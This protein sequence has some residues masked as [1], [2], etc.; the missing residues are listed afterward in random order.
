M[1][2]QQR[3]VTGVVCLLTA[4]VFTILL[5]ARRYST[6][7][8]EVAAGDTAARSSS[9]RQ[10]AI[11]QFRLSHHTQPQAVNSESAADEPSAMNG[12]VTS[13]EIDAEHAAVFD[14]FKRWTE[15]YI[16][17]K[18]QLG[19][20]SLVRTGESLA[21]KRRTVLA[22]LIQSDP[23]HALQM[24]VPYASRRELPSAIARH[25]EERVG[26]K[27]KLEVIASVAAPG[28]QPPRS[29][30]DRVVTLRDRTFKA[31]VYGRRANQSSIGNISLHGIAV[32]DVMAV[33]ES[34]VRLV[35]PLELADMPAPANAGHCP[36]SSDPGSSGVAVQAADEVFYLC[37]AGHIVP[38]A[39]AYI[40]AE[41]AGDRTRMASMTA[42]ATAEL[43]LFTQGEKSILFMRV[44][45][46]DDLE[47]PISEIQAKDMMDEVNSFYVANSYGTLSLNTVISP[48]L[49]LPK[50]KSWYTSNDELTVT[51]PT[52]LADAREAA[53]AAGL[54]QTDL[55]VVYVKRGILSNSRA[56]VGS[57]GA[58]L[59]TV[60][61]Y[62]AAHEIGHNLGLW[63]ANA[64]KTTDGTSTGPGS[65]IEYANSFDTMG[66]G[67]GH[68]NA[69]HKNRLNWLP[70]SAVQTITTS[71]VYRIYPADL[72][73]LKEDAVHALKIRK[74]NQREYWIEA[75]QSFG[76]SLFVNWSANP[77][78]L[79]G[80]QLLDMT[81]E[82]PSFNDAMLAPGN[83]FYDSTLGLKI[84]PLHPKAVNQETIEVLVKLVHYVPVE[85]ETAAIGQP[86]QPDPSASQG[87]YIVVPDR[88]HGGVQFSVSIPES[89]EYTVWTRVRGSS[90]ATIWVGVD[91]EAETQLVLSPAPSVEWQWSRLSTGSFPGKKVLT[92]S[93]GLH[94]LHFA[95]HEGGLMIDCLLIGSDDPTD[96]IPPAISPISNQV[97]VAGEPIHIPFSV[98]QPGTSAADWRITAQSLDQRLIRDIGIVIS[99]DG[100]NRTLEITPNA[101]QFGTAGI[102][103]NLVDS[104]G[105]AI[106]KSF[107][108]SLMGP[109]QAVVE[110]SVPGDTI[111][112]PEGTYVEQLVINKDL[113]L[114]GTGVGQTVIEGNKILVPLT[115]TSNAT[116][117]VRNLTFRKGKTAIRN[118]G[119]LT[120]VESSI[121]E[122]LSAYG[123]GIWNGKNATLL[124]ESSTISGNRVSEQGGGIYNMGELTVLNST[125]SGNRST[126]RKDGNGGGGIYNRGVLSLQNCTITA[127]QGWIGGGVMNV[128]FAQARSTILAV[129]TA[130]AGV[131]ADFEG[132]LVSQ[133]HNL[134]Q[135]IDGCRMTGD[136]TRNIIGQ[137]PRLGALGDNGG[138]TFTH[139]LLPE[140]PAINGGSANGLV[141][142][143]R[144]FPRHPKSGELADG[145]DGS[146]IG[147]FEYGADLPSQGAQL[148]VHIEPNGG[149]S[150][151]VMGPSGS[152]WTVQATSDFV[153]WE[154]LGLVTAENG[155]GQIM[156]ETAYQSGEQALRF[157]RALSY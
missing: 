132:E 104:H 20:D 151:S 143:Q 10:K 127:N 58:W 145:G 84:I 82:S 97:S 29:S 53:A 114:E 85:A 93:S 95:G 156:D 1:R 131:S 72:P 89:G 52:I 149:V 103:I 78:S 146:D 152:H 92:L 2:T 64:W 123:G 71:G 6:V 134:L 157:Y 115:I 79:G 128:G 46:P 141:L 137:D 102:T 49:T 42:A 81:P 111:V 44:N 91:G 5:T 130:E 153:N 133:G 38:L 110:A 61:P 83:G 75:G 47:E 126:S 70:A 45:F 15:H 108:I 67:T 59:Q 139:A 154:T 99:G 106:T 11:D 68:F 33:H 43:N 125:I 73:A 87:A 65:T 4:V 117:V 60:Y 98:I 118:Y 56:Y 3:I 147:A 101:N 116:V 94:T 74:D 112:I 142:D 26:G 35:E 90:S 41:E 129:N 30:I 80:S 51:L 12:S 122:N 57:K 23:E 28:E 31:F 55:D 25:L 119:R 48:L 8:H 62:I 76:S 88:S 136:S 13:Q 109:I 39:A 40:A 22:E 36:V 124:I 86:L 34:P 105:T 150:I 77:W 17:R 66:S 21:I 121:Q 32:G 18:D 120:I 144:G 113:T 138:A 155:I 135:S 100:I 24:A 69:Y 54:P 7:S 16:S 148:S 50:N 9:G 27:G 14:A 37:D 63:H 19:A 140:S 96:F 107:T